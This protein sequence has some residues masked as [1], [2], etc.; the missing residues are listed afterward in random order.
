MQVLKKKGTLSS[1]GSLTIRQNQLFL[2]WSWQYKTVTSYLRRRQLKRKRSV[3][4][5]LIFFSTGESHIIRGESISL[6]PPSLKSQGTPMSRKQL[7]TRRWRERQTEGACVCVWRGGGDITKTWWKAEREKKTHHTADFEIA[8]C[9]LCLLYFTSHY[10][11]GAFLEMAVVSYC[12]WNNNDSR[13]M[14]L[15]FA[16]K[17]HAAAVLPVTPT[18]KGSL[19]CHLYLR[20]DTVHN[21]SMYTN[22][23]EFHKVL[24]L[25]Q[26]Y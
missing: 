2:A 14:F 11:V 1:K 25:D 4:C 3:P 10:V 7:A 20:P 13:L 17:R 8:L 5:I 12:D 18:Q 24:Y 19:V 23:M 16:E 22:V 6:I 21:L 26:Y 9:Q 15:L